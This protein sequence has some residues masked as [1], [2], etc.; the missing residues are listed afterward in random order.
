[1]V[2]DRLLVKE[3]ERTEELTRQVEGLKGHLSAHERLAAKG[4]YYTQEEL[5]IHDKSVMKRLIHSAKRYDPEVRGGCECC[6]TWI[7]HEEAKSGD[8]LSFYEV[9]ELIEGWSC[10]PAT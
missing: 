8:Y 3:K 4:I 10:K 5:D 9:M 1:M 7:E 6:G 2:P